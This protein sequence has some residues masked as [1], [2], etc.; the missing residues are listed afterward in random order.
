V[1]GQPVLASRANPLAQANRKMT[2][3]IE[4]WYPGRARTPLKFVH[5]VLP[6]SRVLST[7]ASI[8]GLILLSNGDMN[9]PIERVPY[10]SYLQRVL[11]SWSI[12]INIV[13]VAK[14]PGS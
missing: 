2:L 14:T 12:G 6:A 5:G 7:R 1:K 13:L 9:L 3:S 11:C 10:S 8:G 4:T